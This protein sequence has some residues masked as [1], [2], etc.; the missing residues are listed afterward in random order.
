M[1]KNGFIPA[2]PFVLPILWA[3]P[4]YAQVSIQ[5]TVYDKTMINGLPQVT[6]SNT[7]GAIAVSDSSGHY[8]IRVAKED[9]IYFSYLN[10]RTAA[11]PVKDIPDPATFSVSIEVTGPALMPVYVNHNSYYADSVLNRRENRE[12]FDYKHG[13]FV[14]NIRLMPGGQG[15]M[16]GAAL[17]MD[18]FFHRDIR[19]SKQLIQRWLIEEEQDKYIDHRFNRA[20]VKRITGLDSADLRLFMRIY[21][22]GY[23][24]TRSFQT[25]WEL[26][27]YILASSRSFLAD[28][29]RDPT[30]QTDSINLLP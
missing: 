19:R 16:A 4:V 3:S 9:T 7:R 2:I 18:I 14:R 27:S 30:R 15:L 22:P 5:G 23:E 12:G 21:R 11:F 10:K 26:Y 17:D 13:S 8:S 28:Q 20:I 25:D 1:K 6:I 24:V 29:K